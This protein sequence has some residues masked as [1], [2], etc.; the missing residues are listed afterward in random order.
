MSKPRKTMAE[1][2]RLTG[3]N[4]STVSRALNDSP[5]VKSDT[6]AEILRVASEIGYSV[7][8]AARNL[9]RQSSNTI[10]L[11]IPL[12]P[13]SGETISDPFFLEMVGAV[14][15]AASK[16]GYDLLLSTPE[17]EGAIAERRLLQTG[18]ADGLIIIGQAGREDRLQEI[19]EMENRIVVWGGLKD[20]APYTL[21]GSDNRRGGQLATDHLI[22]LGR[23]RIL[24]IGDTALPEIALRFEGYVDSHKGAELKLDPDLLLPIGFGHQ[25]RDVVPQLSELLASGT[26][27]D[28]VFA[29]SDALAIMAMD[30]LRQNGLAVPKDV[31]VVGYDNIGQAALAQP[32]LTT[33]SQN[34]AMGGELLVSALID[35]LEGKSV[36][37]ALTETELVVRE[38]CG[39]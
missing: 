11:V 14:S 32:A 26:Q 28:A 38:S 1:L 16:R 37:S 15:M 2:A 18:R 17:D 34:I 36:Q 25:V 31:S 27:I 24:F 5:L 10:A 21:I 4:V 33:V 19:S 23:K 12:R 7:N 6:K 3:V 20:G 9:R 35:K 39:P 22:K 13:D 8:V 30:A 29:A